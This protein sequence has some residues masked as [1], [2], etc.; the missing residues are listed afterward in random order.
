MGEYLQVMTTT[1]AQTDAQ[2][3]ARALVEQRLAACVQVIGP[4]ISTYRWQGQIEEAQEYLCLIKTRADRFEQVEA[5][6]RAAHP[7]EVP[8]I[9]AV[10]VAAGSA[11]Y[12]RWL[13]GEIGGA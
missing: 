11:D 5:A 8:E 2:R 9:L 1:A 3:I 13:D 6:I 7:Y 4:M 10:P 12:L